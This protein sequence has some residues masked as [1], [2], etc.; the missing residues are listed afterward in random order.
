MR[1]NSSLDGFVGRALPGLL[2]FLAISAAYLYTFPQANVFYAAVVL[3]HALAGL[4]TAILLIPALFRLLPKGSFLARASWML[5]AAS[6]VLG[7]ILIKTRPP[8][9]PCNR[10]R[11]H[12]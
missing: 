2:V 8:L 11:P 1:D 3:L 9:P 6:A 7:L 4:V 10:L 12:M 5:I